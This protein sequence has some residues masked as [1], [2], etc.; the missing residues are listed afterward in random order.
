MATKT[1]DDQEKKRAS[2]KALDAL[3]ALEAEFSKVEL[4]QRMSGM[5]VR[6]TL[7]VGEKVAGASTD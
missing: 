7:L 5:N 3:S 6:P 4:E 2:E 1:T